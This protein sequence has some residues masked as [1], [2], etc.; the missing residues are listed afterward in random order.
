M[1]TEEYTRMHYR[2]RVQGHLSISWQAWFEG[3]QITQEEQGTT[4]FAG[5]L[6]DQAALYGV[7]LKMRS[8]NLI[9][10]SLDTGTVPE[11][12]A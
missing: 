1:G 4:L 10:L 2:I 11:K 5:P 3:L 12:E 7:L 9:L 8:L 6:Q